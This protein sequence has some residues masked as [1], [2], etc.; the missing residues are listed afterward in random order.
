MTFYSHI[1]TELLETYDM[2]NIV[3]SIIGL[4]KEKTY[5]IQEGINNA[6]FSAETGYSSKADFLSVERFLQYMCDEGYLI[7]TEE[8]ENTF[9][10]AHKTVLWSVSPEVLSKIFKPI[11]PESTC[12]VS[13]P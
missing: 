12:K 4:K 5:K 8:G 7:K 3:I 10:Y 6:L 11:C 9:Y 1:F 2:E 13:A